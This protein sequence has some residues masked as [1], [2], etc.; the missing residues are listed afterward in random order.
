MTADVHSDHPLRQLFCGLVEQ[1][2]QTDL[3]VCDPALTTYLGDMLVDFTHVEQIFP[4]RDVNGEVIREISRLRA[5]AVLGPQIGAFDR[6]RVIN[7]Y[8]GDVTLFWAGVYPETLRPRL[9]GADRLRE[10]LLQG[11]QSYG[12]AS[13]LSDDGDLPPAALLRCLS[14]QFEFC[15]HGLRLVR[16]G[17][18]ELSRQYKG[19]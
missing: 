13:E 11:K 3:G 17:W 14:R 1:V 18:E 10:Y 8:I 15:V 16:A 2:F 9:A 6:G 7:R 4:H 5:D 19:N 12:V